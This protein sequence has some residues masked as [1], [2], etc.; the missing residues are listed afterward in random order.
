VQQLIER[1]GP[2][3]DKW[4]LGKLEID[5]YSDIVRYSRDDVDLVSGVSCISSKLPSPLSRPVRRP[6]DFSPSSSTSGRIDP[7]RPADLPTATVAARRRVK[8]ET[9][10]AR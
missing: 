10:A 6:R 8:R 5:D 4:N 2:K 1:T 7:E 3:R 9:K